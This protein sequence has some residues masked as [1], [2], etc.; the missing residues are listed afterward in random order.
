MDFLICPLLLWKPAMMAKR[1]MNTTKLPTETAEL[2]AIVNT[3]QR[4]QLAPGDL[5]PEKPG[6]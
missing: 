1:R 5:G 6:V 2:G 4:N 3:K